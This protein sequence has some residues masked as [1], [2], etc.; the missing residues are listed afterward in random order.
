VK[1]SHPNVS[2]IEN[3]RTPR[4]DLDSLYG[5]DPAAAEFLY[6]SDGCFRLGRTTAV[7]HPTGPAGVSEQDLYRDPTGTACLVD[8]RNDENLLVAQLHVLFATLHNRCMRLLGQRRDLAPDP[9]DS[10]LFR[11]TRTLVTWLYQWIIKHE[12]LPSFVRSSVLDQVFEGKLRLYPRAFTPTHYPIS[13]PIEFTAAAYRFGH[14]VIQESYFLNDHAAVDTG[15][16]RQPGRGRCH[17]SPP[18]RAEAARLA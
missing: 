8:A 18:R 5:K 12:F 6:D 17:A 16:R 1:D 9:G 2:A 3:Y 10:D 11:Q 13:L 14:S 15:T 4:L 7:N